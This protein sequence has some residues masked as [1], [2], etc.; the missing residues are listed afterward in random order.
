MADEELRDLIAA[1]LW[2]HMHP[3]REAHEYERRRSKDTS[4]ATSAKFL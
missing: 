3:S 4:T 2:T 1:F